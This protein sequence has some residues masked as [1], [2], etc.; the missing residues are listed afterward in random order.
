MPP[1][2]PR[3]LDEAPEGTVP[4]YVQGRG[5]RDKVSLRCWGPN[6]IQRSPISPISP[7]SP[8]SPLDNAGGRG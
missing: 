2:D 8:K 5:Q 3:K 1:S 6:W 4:Q 7:I